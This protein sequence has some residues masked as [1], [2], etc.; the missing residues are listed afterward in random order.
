MASRTLRIITPENIPLELELAGLGLRF[1][2]LLIDLVILTTFLILLWTLGVFLI[3]L[4]QAVG[5]GDFATGLLV[6][7]SF[8]CLFGYFILFEALWNGQTP[9]K[10]FL[11]LRVIQDSGFPVTFFSVANRNL[12]RIADFLPGF[13][14]VG[15][16]SVFCNPQ[17]KR[18]GDLVAGT[19]VIKE[20]SAAVLSNGP[21]GPPRREQDYLANARLASNVTDPRTVLSEVELELMRR[22]SLRRWEMEYVDAERFAARLLAPMVAKLNLRFVPGQPPRYADIIS[23]IVRIVD[24]IEEAEW[25]AI[26]RD[27]LTGSGYTPAKENRDE[28]I[29]S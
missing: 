7:T 24:G 6:F 20:R 25:R 22:F 10:R 29:R 13:F 21:L 2:A 28:R 26:R 17:Y 16:V 12:I 23:V 9:G 4:M 27:E 19:V 8:L 11:G 14:G 18:L 15:A 1:G 5:Q 3:A